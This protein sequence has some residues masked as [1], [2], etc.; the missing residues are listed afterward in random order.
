MTLGVIGESGAGKTTLALALAA[1]I[2]PAWAEVSGEVIFEGRNLLAQK[3]RDLCLIRGAGIGMVF[4]DATGSLDPSVPVI[5]QVAEAIMFQRDWNK[6]KAAALEKAGRFLADMGLSPE[7][8]A[9][10]PYSYQ[11]SGG[12]CQ[13]AMIAAALAC[14]PLLLLADEPTSSLDTTIQAQIIG[15]LKEKQRS[16]D[17]AMIFISHDLA[18]VST[19]A[20]RILVMRK[21]FA[22]EQGEVSKV[23]NRPAHEYTAELVDTW[24]AASRRERD[25]VASA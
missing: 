3:E 24:E 16:S 12:L 1:L 11:L 6:S 17:L 2:E 18:L 4:Q 7:L 14:R 25:T 5:K 22:V 21:G 19:V 20:D 23:L 13:R 8:L 15:L 10:A 9:S